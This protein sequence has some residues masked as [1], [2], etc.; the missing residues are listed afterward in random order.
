MNYKKI[1]QPKWSLFIILISFI[2]SFINANYD[3]AFFQYSILFTSVIYHHNLEKNFRFIDMFVV[4]VGLW[5]HIYTY[6]ANEC[7]KKSC[8]FLILYILGISFYFVGLY[9]NNNIFH[10]G[11]HIFP[12]LGNISLNN[13]L[14]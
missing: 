7:Y 10:C 8:A 11:T 14:Y 4:Q 5:F 12:V 13:I 2:H 9:T 6:F 1:L 3:L